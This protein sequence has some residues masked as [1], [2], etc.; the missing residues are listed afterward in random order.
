[1]ETVFLIITL[2]AMLAAPYAT[3][4]IAKAKY[5]CK[6]NKPPE[7][8]LPNF[9]YDVEPPTGKIEKISTEEENE[10]IQNNLY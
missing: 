1:M 3:F 6:T 8:T 2:V 4:M 5:Q 7:N 10:F 9:E